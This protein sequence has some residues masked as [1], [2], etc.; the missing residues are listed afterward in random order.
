M[1]INIKVIPESE[2]RAE[3]NGADW[4]Y[5]ET[6][7]LQ[8]RISPLKDWRHEVLLQF[9]EAIEAVICKHLGISQQAVDKFDQQ[10]DLEHPNEP[11]LNAGDDPLAP[12]DRAHTLATACERA[13]AFA[14]DVQWGD[15]DRELG[16]NYPGPSKKSGANPA[17]TKPVPGTDIQPEG[18]AGV[19][20]GKPEATH[21]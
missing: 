9:H 4:Y 10:F 12:Y 3:V 6:G 11:D 2:Q 16:Q 1:D 7:N 17:D 20:E 15:Y 13:M 19:D 5:D 18:G 21:G 8:V 14:L